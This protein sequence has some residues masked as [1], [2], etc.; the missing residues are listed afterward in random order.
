MA[1]VANPL[2][3]K[4]L[5]WGSGAGLVVDGDDLVVVA[6]RVRPDRLAL[7]GA[8]RITG[9][10]Q[11][12]ASDW[13][14]ELNRWLT[15]HGLRRTPLMV[16]LPAGRVV[17]RTIALPGVAD[18]D[19]SQAIQFQLDGLHPWGE[20]EVAWD[21]QRVGAAGHF[22]V[23]VAEREFVDRM[24]TL[25]AEAGLR[26]KG[27]SA[28]ASVLYHARRLADGGPDGGAVLAVRGLYAGAAGGEECEIYG[29]APAHPLRGGLVGAPLER[30]LA[31]VAAELRMEEPVVPA[32]WCDVVPRWDR[33][34][35]GFEAS[36]AN[37]SRLALGWAAAL[38]A[39]CGH[40]GAPANLLPRELRVQSSGWIWAPTLVLAA[41][42]A[43][44]CVAL[45]AQPVWL[46]RAYVQAL[47]QQSRQMHS[48]AVKVE[49]L[50][51]HSADAA[52]RIQ[53]LD[54]YRE[55]TREDLDAL[56]ELTRLLPP[57]AALNSLVLTRQD[58]QIAG[59]GAQAEVLL[60][61]FDESP[62]FEKTEFTAQLGREG[63]KDVFRLRTRRR[64]VKAASAQAPAP[65]Q[66]P[67]PHAGGKK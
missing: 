8:V 55:R 63:D 45:A 18:A 12:P 20:Q 67:A 34:P 32:D 30:A 22:H 25:C 59:T 42:L 38:L 31:G 17:A 9:Y 50:T 58:V 19:A 60:K 65:P 16:V 48:L 2:L 10:A 37:R 28:A 61:R 54:D 40:L 5:R 49:E 21:A 43:G 29:E 11:R 66:P 47:H 3:R 53:Q 41:V 27:F 14:A 56:L 33:A 6:A 24:A 23:V 51:R 52:E 57:P 4:W 39:P 36:D 26:L 35:D 15:A 64:A 7:A 13:G 44:L 1:L 46:D 62:L